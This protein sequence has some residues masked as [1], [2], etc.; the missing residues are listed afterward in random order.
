M[1]DPV[2]YIE[3]KRKRGVGTVMAAVRYTFPVFLGYMATGIAFGLLLA[4][5]GYPW[6]LALAMGILMYAG[7]GQYLAVGLFA[8]GAGLAEAVLLQFILN[9]RH[10]AY[11][12]TLG[13]RINASGPF[14]F[15]LI[16][17][18]TDETFALLSSL[19]EGNGPGETGSRPSFMCMTALLNQC[20]WVC[21][22][23]IGAVAGTLIP[24][25]LEGI[26]FALTALFIVLMIE[27]ILRV[28]RPAPFVISS[29]A[30]ALASFLL[31][32]RF[33]LLTALVFS[34]ALTQL[35]AA[36]EPDTGR[37]AS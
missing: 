11:G 17:A 34:L 26:S 31:P 14:K 29:L 23:I 12:I 10:I 20:Y 15:Y 27:Q 13:R 9:I 32:S 7:A 36:P 19:P 22:S 30:A 21:G 6:H 24:F 28:R 18:L 37:E 5:A 8:S 4:D 25:N 2:E 1:K 33:S 35:F 3:T 16:Y